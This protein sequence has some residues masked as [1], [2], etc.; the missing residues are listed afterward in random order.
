MFCHKG[1]WIQCPMCDSKFSDS[2]TIDR[3]IALKSHL[4]EVH[5]TECTEST[6]ASMFLETQLL[7]ENINQNQQEVYIQDV[8]TVVENEVTLPEVSENEQVREKKFSTIS[9]RFLNPNYFLQFQ[10][11]IKSE[12]LPGTS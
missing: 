11:C 1:E 2:F 5:D 6:I 9:F 10:L 12:K 3:K 7:K 8:H 4:L